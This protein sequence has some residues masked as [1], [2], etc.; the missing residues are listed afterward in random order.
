MMGDVVA[1][2]VAHFV[3][4]AVLG[5]FLPFHGDSSLNVV[6]LHLVV[7]QKFET[8]H[9]GSQIVAG[10]LHIAAHAKVLLCLCIVEPVLALNVVGFL[11]LGVEG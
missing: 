9:V 10:M 3:L 8:L 6:A 7:E 5:D 1:A 4:A 11:L 2:G